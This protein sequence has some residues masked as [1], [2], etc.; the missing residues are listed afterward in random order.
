MC[1]HVF[2]L[3]TEPASA[4]VDDE[5][6]A[7]EDGAQLLFLII[8]IV[9]S[10]EVL[11][12]AIEITENVQELVHHFNV[13]G[14]FLIRCILSHEVVQGLLLVLLQQLVHGGDGEVFYRCTGLAALPSGIGCKLG[15]DSCPFFFRKGLLTGRDGHAFQHL[16]LSCPSRV[17]RSGKIH[18]C[19]AGDAGNRIGCNLVSLHR[20][21][22]SADGFDARS[23]YIER[24]G[25]VGR[26]LGQLVT[27]KEVLHLG[28][29][30]LISCNHGIGLVTERCRYFGSTPIR[31]SL[32]LG[33]ELLD[34]RGGDA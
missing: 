12:Q 16:E 28:I 7:L 1:R 13:V 24:H 6:T 29:Q 26:E 20:E 3:H 8:E 19:L 30:C 34:L 31:V 22:F 17:D 33:I 11:Q 4:L 25:A 32:E 18:R 27:H 21:V 9:E 10:D 5:R 23:L 2:H 15:A 14:F